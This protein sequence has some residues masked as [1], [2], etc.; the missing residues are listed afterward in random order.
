LAILFFVIFKRREQFVCTF[1]QN[2]LAC[3][4]HC[5]A[6]QLDNVVFIPSAISAAGMINEHNCPALKL[7]LSG[8][9]ASCFGRTVNLVRRST[10][11]RSQLLFFLPLI[12]WD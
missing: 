2:T 7:N 1:L 3:D 4:F 10:E 9:A 5:R 12:Y 6:G 8:H 11:I